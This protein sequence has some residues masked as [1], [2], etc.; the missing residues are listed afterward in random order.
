[1][2]LR[3]KRGDGLTGATLQGNVI[4]NG[5]AEARWLHLCLVE[6]RSSAETRACLPQRKLSREVGSGQQETMKGGATKRII[7]LIEK[8]DSEGML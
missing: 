3:C 8:L 4:E 7:K 1:M 2:S 6:G 5:Q